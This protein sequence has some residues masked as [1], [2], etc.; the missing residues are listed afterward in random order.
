[1]PGMK[2]QA[3]KGMLPRVA[4][5]LLPEGYAQLARNVKLHSGDLIPYRTPVPVPNVGSFTN[6]KTLYKNGTTWGHYDTD[7]DIVNISTGMGAGRRTYRADGVSPPMVDNILLGLPIPTQIPRASFEDYNPAQVQRFSREGNIA[8]VQAAYVVG[9][10]GS[11]FYRVGEVI[12]ISGLEDASFNVQNVVVRSSYTALGSQVI[13]YFNPGPD[14]ADG[15][16]IGGTVDLAGTPQTRNYVYTFI[17]HMGEESIPSVP[18]HAQFV[19]EGV[20]VVVSNLPTTHPLDRDDIKGIRLYRTVT[21]AGGT[22]YLRLTTLWFAGQAPDTDIDPTPEFVGSDGTYDDRESVNDLSIALPSID[23]DAPPDGRD[24]KPIL[25]GLRE[26]HNNILVG[27][28]GTELC[29]SLP[30]VPHAWPERHRLSLPSEITAV[31][32]TQGAILVLTKDYPYIVSGNDPSTMTAIRL[33][34]PYGCKYKRSVVVLDSGVMWVT[35]A[36]L[37]LYQSGG[38]LRLLTEASIAWDDWIEWLELQGGEDVRAWYYEGKYLASTGGKS[39]IYHSTQ[40]EGYIVELSNT[41]DAGYYDRDSG[42]FFFV[43]GGT[44]YQWDAHTTDNLEMVWCSKRFVSPIPVNYGAVKLEADF[45]TSTTFTLRRGI[46]ASQCCEYVTR[47]N[48]PFRLPAGFKDD[49][50]DIIITGRSRVRSVHVTETVRG[51]RGV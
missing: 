18:S 51:L 45:S 13:R 16:K 29:F 42:E 43:E 1:M 35:D 38:G 21:S 4:P 34:T 23:Y 36:G 5:E 49:T 17:T 39:F 25:H 47:N 33:N 20:D 32:P 31:E 19:V 46:P 3:F 26:A 37:A 24:G 40:Q 48:A 50:Y 41:F 28:A 7:T 11:I 15:V 6:A 8:S 30:N 12:S 9:R 22:S 14:V 27:F 44:L 2:L 10:A